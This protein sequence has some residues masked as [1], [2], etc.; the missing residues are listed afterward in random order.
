MPFKATLTFSC[1]KEH[2]CVGCGGAYRYKFT[3]TVTA[4]AETEPAAGEAVE[5]EAMKKATAEV[6]ERPCPE[7]GSVQSDMI[8][9]EKSKVH[10]GVMGI[11]AVVAVVALIM[12]GIPSATWMPYSLAA[13][14]V[15]VVSLC[16]VLLHWFTGLNNPNGNK[17]KNLDK[18]AKLVDDGEME[19]MKASN[20]DRAEGDPPAVAA[21]ATLWLILATASLPLIGAPVLLKAATGWASNTD[22]KPD[23]IGPGDRVRV[24]I[25][26]PITCV[27]SRWTGVAAATAK[28][29]D[30]R[31]VS[32]PVQTQSDSWGNSI[33]VKSSEKDTRPTLWADVTLP[34]E[35]A[36]QKVNLD[37]QMAVRYPTMGIGNMF[38]ETATT[39]S[40]SREL[41]LSSARAGHTYWLTFWAM[42]GGSVL[43]ALAGRMLSRAAGGLKEFAPDNRVAPIREGGRRRPPSD[44]DADE[45]DWKK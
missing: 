16:G 28:L 9:Q 6:D 45:G 14:I 38:N 17:Q 29:A 15:G 10:L 22:I 2:R 5:A 3:R 24:Y 37:V 36:G 1:W 31:T 12:A 25:G 20:P 41:V 4:A 33:S 35:A 13:T 40:H 18:A 11:V 26:K 44:D 39:A 8:A 7:C 34:P 43:L 27:Q 42:A 23:V 19:V 30:G 32:V 21:S